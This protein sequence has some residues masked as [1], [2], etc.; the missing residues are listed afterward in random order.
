MYTKLLARA[1]ESCLGYSAIT[2]WIRSLTRGEDIHG[3]ASGGRLLPD[4]RVDPL[5]I[6][7]LE[8][9]RFHS[10]RS[11]A[12]TIKIPPT[13]GWR[14]LHARDYVVRNMHIVPH[15]LSLAQKAD[16][17]EAAIELKK[18]LCSGKHCDWRYILMGDELWF[19][20]TTNPDYAWVPGRAVTAT[21]PRQ[22]I[23]SSKRMLTVF[24]SPLGFPLVQILPKGHHF[25]A[26]YLCNHRLH[27]I[28]RIRPATTDEDA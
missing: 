6:N 26:E 3:H 1:R 24:W 22:I 10:V 18:V 2:N 28:D 27:G 23:S 16:R 11:L 17:V 9:A 25:H 21:R 4:D 20:F 14:H 15:M 12:S 19:Y 13:T 7:A 8:E 5:V